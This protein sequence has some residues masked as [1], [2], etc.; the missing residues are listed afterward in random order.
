[1]LGKNDVKLR[2]TL[3]EAKMFDKRGLT[4]YGKLSNNVGSNNVE[5]FYP[6]W[7]NSLAT[8]LSHVFQFSGLSL[9]GQVTVLDED[10]LY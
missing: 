3:D 8:N 6:T 7:L 5:L 10:I 2:P 1:M 9:R 4:R